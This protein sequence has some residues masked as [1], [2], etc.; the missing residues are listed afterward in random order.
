M[1]K[2]EWCDPLH[3]PSPEEFIKVKAVRVGNLPKEATTDMV[4]AKFEAYGK[5]AGVQKKRDYAFVH[6]EE[7]ESAETGTVPVL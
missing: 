3:E 2:V 7:R 1:I 6:Y 4:R 5:L